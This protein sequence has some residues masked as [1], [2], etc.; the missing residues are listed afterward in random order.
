LEAQSFLVAVKELATG[1]SRHQI[2]GTP[3]FGGKTT[4]ES[5]SRR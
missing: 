5:P 1:L 3:R 2:D 4:L